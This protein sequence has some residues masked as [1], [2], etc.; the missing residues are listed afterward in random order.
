MPG[1][2]VLEVAVAVGVDRDLERCS[3]L[4]EACDGC[5]VEQ[6]EPGQVGRRK[7]T[8][9]GEG[10]EVVGQARRRHHAVEGLTLQSQRGG[11]GDNEPLPSQVPH[12][13]MRE[14]LSNRHNDGGHLLR[15]DV[16]KLDPLLEDTI[17]TQ[18][19]ARQTVELLAIQI[20][21]TRKP[22]RCDL[23]RDE[24]VALRRPQE[25]VAPVLEVE[26]DIGPPQNSVIHV[27]E[28]L[29]RCRDDPGRDLSDVH[30]AKT[31]RLHDVRRVAGPETYDQRTIPRGRMEDGHQSKGHLGRHLAGVIALKLA[32][33]EQHPRGLAGRGDGVRDDSRE[34][35]GRVLV[36]EQEPR[37]LRAR[38]SH[39]G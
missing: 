30:V 18:P 12:R 6:P 38:W 37:L 24:V 2:R 1:C 28:T 7:S 14:D 8:D 20:G 25:E 34:A 13:R 29:V 19:R 3:S 21:G 31:G 17:L 4:R 23:H 10:L 26:R 5:G 32:V 39:P 11:R 16:M 22:N 27:A 9:P 33:G 35:A 36:E 15:V